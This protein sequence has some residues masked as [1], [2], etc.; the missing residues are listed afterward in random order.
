[1]KPKF[2]NLG[3]LV[4]CLTFSFTLQSQNALEH[5]RT[6]FYN[7]SIGAIGGGVGAIFNRPDGEKIGSAFLR[8]MWKGAAGGAVIYGS[9]FAVR[10]LYKRNNT[11]FLWTSKIINSVGTSMVENAAL[12]RNLF[13]TLHINIGFSRVQFYLKDK[14]KVQ[15][16]IIL[17]PML[18]FAVKLG[19]GKFDLKR[20]AE[21][22]TFVFVDNNSQFSS[23]YTPNSIYLDG[24]GIDNDY[25]NEVI[26]SFQ[27]TNFYFINNCL[28][29][30]RESRIEKQGKIVLLDKIFYSDVFSTL[31]Y[32]VYENRNN[33]LRNEANYFSNRF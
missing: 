20:S 23:T 21:S 24:N 12:N 19:Q 31:F 32:E 4:L 25:H 29:K 18:G 27:Y 15:H 6:A 10:G 3:C 33:Y 16:R 22:L 1:M 30:W 2:L 26:R 9:K 13:E 17:V 28:H 11:S 14:F 5:G 7:I 8:G